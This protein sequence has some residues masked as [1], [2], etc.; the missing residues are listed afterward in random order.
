MYR[1]AD[2]IKMKRMLKKRNTNIPRIT[3][4]HTRII[5][6]EKKIE[7][8]TFLKRVLN[9]SLREWKRNVMNVADEYCWAMT[10]TTGRSCCGRSGSPVSQFQHPCLP[11]CNSFHCYTIY[12]SS[13]AFRLICLFTESSGV[14]LFG[15]ITSSSS[16]Y[17][18]FPV[19]CWTCT[20]V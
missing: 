2:N 19:S 16:Y 12:R 5:T 8:Y 10:E 1:W 6:K 7:K 3:Q 20:K 4:F 11:I 9:F 15:F 13:A 14:K 17:Y 18:Y